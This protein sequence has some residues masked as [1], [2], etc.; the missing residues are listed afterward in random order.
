[1]SF[2][3]KLGAMKDTELRGILLEKFYE[4]TKRGGFYSPQAEDFTPPIP[5]EDLLAVSDQLGQYGLI[6]W[7][8]RRSHGRGT[9]GAILEGVGNI[10]ARGIDVVEGEAV[11]DLK[12]EFVQNN[13]TITNSPGV[14]VGDHNNQS[15]VHHVTELAKAIDASEA[16]TEQKA[17]AKSLLRKFIEHPAVNTVAG[18]L[19]SKLLG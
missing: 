9:Y 10:T 18:T 8:C 3:S 12:V 7:K 13:V 19:L 6:T 5:R 17:E 11:S 14:I 2:S 4:Q 1:M 15:I 16:T